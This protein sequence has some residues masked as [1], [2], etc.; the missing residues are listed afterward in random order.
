[1]NKIFAALLLT[2]AASASAEPTLIE[3]LAGPSLVEPT[4]V[5]QLAEPP[6]VEPLCEPAIT[7][8]YTPNGYDVYYPAG[9]ANEW[10]VSRT[11]YG[12]TG[13]ELL[14]KAGQVSRDTTRALLN[15]GSVIDAAFPDQ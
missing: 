6:L 13:L 12:N 4:L 5:E 2:A 14:E 3:Q 8:I 1:M 7:T 15:G 11:S 10:S 9:K